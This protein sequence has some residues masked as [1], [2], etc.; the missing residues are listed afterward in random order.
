MKR[1]IFYL[2]ILTIFSTLA[3]CGGSPI[4]LD[5]EG[6]TNPVNTGAVSALTFSQSSFSPYIYV[7]SDKSY[8]RISYGFFPDGSEFDFSKQTITIACSFLVSTPEGI[9]IQSSTPMETNCEPYILDLAKNGESFTVDGILIPIAGN[10]LQMEP[11]FGIILSTDGV[12]DSTDGTILTASSGK[13]EDYY[14]QILDRV[15]TE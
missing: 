6:L 7:N 4:N 10:Y 8:L 1:V 14:K 15:D 11:D 9:D 5:T 2:S 13:L 3:S 12:K